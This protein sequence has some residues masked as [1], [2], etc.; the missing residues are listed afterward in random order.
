MNSNLFIPSDG[1][2]LISHTAGVKLA[3]QSRLARARHVRV[4]YC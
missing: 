2:H 4:Y 3:R 1:V